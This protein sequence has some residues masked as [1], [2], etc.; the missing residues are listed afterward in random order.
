MPSVYR[1]QSDSH[2]TDIHEIS[3]LGRLLIFVNTRKFWLQSGGEKKTEA[4]R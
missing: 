2:W 3:H 4:L 1:E